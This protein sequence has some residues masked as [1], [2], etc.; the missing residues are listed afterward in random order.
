MLVHQSFEWDFAADYG[1][2]NFLDAG[3]TKTVSLAWKAEWRSSAF[4]RLEERTR[5]PG[6]TDRFTFRKPLVD[7]L[8]C[9]PGDI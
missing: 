4:V 6:R 2:A 5:R 3:W 7:R 9:S 1:V 8:K